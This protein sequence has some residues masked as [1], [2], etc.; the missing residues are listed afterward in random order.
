MVLEAKLDPINT[1]IPFR[2]LNTALQ[3]FQLQRS[4]G[5]EKE[6]CKLPFLLS[7]PVNI[8]QLRKVEAPYPRKKYIY[9]HNIYIYKYIFN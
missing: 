4:S 5:S 7:G 8:Q 1:K 9:T 6:V 2:L 3:L